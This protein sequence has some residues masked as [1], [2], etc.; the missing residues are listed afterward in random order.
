VGGTATGNHHATGD[1][2]AGSVYNSL[3]ATG[4]VMSPV[5]DAGRTV[6]RG[7]STGPG[8]GLL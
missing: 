3:D 5:A 7:V 6:I 1:C 4:T 2:Y 8:R